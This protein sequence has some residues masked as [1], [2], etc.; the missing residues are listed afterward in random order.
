MKPA[1]KLR[2]RSQTGA[3]VASENCAAP[4]QSRVS[5]GVPTTS[6]PASSVESSGIGSSN[7]QQTDTKNIR[8]VT[9]GNLL[10]PRTNR[11]IT[12]QR[13]ISLD[14]Q[15][16]ASFPMAQGRAKAAM[17]APTQPT[18]AKILRGKS[19]VPVLVG[20]R[21]I[22]PILGADENQ[23]PVG[24]R[25]AQGSAT[26]MMLA[27][28][29]RHGVRGQQDEGLEKIMD[30]SLG[31]QEQYKP[32]PRATTLGFLQYNSI[33]GLR[34]VT[35]QSENDNSGAPAHGP[36][37]SVPIPR[38][39]PCY[40]STPSI[41]QPMA[42]LSQQITED[43]C[44]RFRTPSPLFFAHEAGHSEY[45]PLGE[46]ALQVFVA[47]EPFHNPGIK[48]K[49]PQPTEIGT[50]DRTLE[51][52]GKVSHFLASPVVSVDMHLNFPDFLV[53]S[54]SSTVLCNWSP[55]PGSV[56][57]DSQLSQSS[58][59]PIKPMHGEKN[60]AHF[61]LYCTP[62]AL[63][64][65]ELQDL[66]PNAM[67]LDAPEPAG[68]PVNTVSMVVPS[69]GGTISKGVDLAR[70]Y[71]DCMTTYFKAQPHDPILDAFFSYSPC[72]TDNNSTTPLSLSLTAF[73]IKFSM[74][75]DQESLPTAVHLAKT[76]W[77][78]L[79][80]V[81]STAGPNDP[82][83]EFFG[84]LLSSSWGIVLAQFGLHGAP[85]QIEARLLLADHLPG[86]ARL[87]TAE[88]FKVK[89]EERLAESFACAERKEKLAA[90][91]SSVD[92]WGIGWWRR[93][94]AVL[95]EGY[96]ENELEKPLLI[97]VLWTEEILLSTLKLAG[98][99]H[100]E[101]WG[102]EDVWRVVIKQ[103]RSRGGIIKIILH[104]GED[105]GNVAILRTEI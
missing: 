68:P 40:E 6:R 2:I 15:K 46:D 29:G 53:N 80:H 21:V 74:E 16:T 38:R 43:D 30:W 66:D 79:D 91:I 86:Y 45:K 98:A 11:I 83:V 4:Q 3:P 55:A 62:P 65:S 72:G 95:A 101:G 92:G 26:S 102:L 41:V 84:S 75:G 44:A 48:S 50:S 61:S 51:T 25:R 12:D 33:T 1:P 10:I 35:V 7:K 73:I 67:D 9:L 94:H 105:L 49:T 93:V 78:G 52:S 57:M 89:L 13:T 70:I 39:Q 59:P 77:L 82:L 87:Y 90:M 71:R 27:E 18:S 28:L 14:S 42:A 47:P 64:T 100:R 32:Q 22:P 104:Q 37:A 60:E 85:N 20:H 17:T 56:V 58:L 19:L 103:A 63:S 23:P 88:G 8:E 76:A 24:P 97:H 99:A 36:W 54:T 81:S 34:G 96:Q 31:E 69:G 5:Y